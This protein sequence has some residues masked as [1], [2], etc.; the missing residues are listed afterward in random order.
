MTRFEK[1]TRR[2]TNAE[3]C[4]E[5]RACWAVLQQ[6][7]QNY[8]TADGFAA[9]ARARALPISNFEERTPTRVLKRNGVAGIGTRLGLS[10]YRR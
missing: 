5:L 1:R 3:R 10:F 2:R 8:G 4:L 9:D 7:P 6:A